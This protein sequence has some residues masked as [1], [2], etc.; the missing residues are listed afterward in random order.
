[1]CHMYG[2]R[3]NKIQDEA[4]QSWQPT[5]DRTEGPLY[6]ALADA[7]EQAI[8]RGELPAGARLPPQRLLAKAL[9]VDLTTITRGY[10]EAQRRGLVSATVG[11]GTFVQAG[12]PDRTA[13]TTQGAQ[14]SAVLDMSM[15]LPPVP[16]APSLRTVLQDGLANLLRHGDMRTLMSYR[17][18]AGTYT[19]RAVAAGWLGPVIG[20]IDPDRVVVAA[21]AQCALTALVTTLTRPG[22][23]VLV[24][25]L[26][27]PGFRAVAAQF[28]VRLV[29]VATDADGPLPAAVERACRG[30]APKAMYL[31]PTIH[32]PSTDTIPPE[33]RDVL[34][35]LA[36]RH[37]MALIE[38]DAYGLFPSVPLTAVT[39]HATGAG[40]YIST[41]AKC[42]APGLR[43]AF[44][45]APGTAEAVRLVS[46]LRATSLSPSPLL[47]NLLTQWLQDGTALALRD[48][49]RSE[50]TERQKLAQAAL[51]TG[52]FASHPEGLHAW[53]TL[54]P[55][56]NR[57]DFCAHV[58]RQGL[59]LVPA[60]AFAIDLPV[61][62]AVRICLGVADR[63]DV[64]DTALRSVA[65]AIQSSPPTPLAE[66]V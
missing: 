12:Q 41:L 20:E 32:N 30:L 9:G 28:G 15:N 50:A 22:D 37:A 10:A 34:A 25:P 2:F 54:P 1:M 62:N 58:R 29:T 16:Q 55:Q 31:V 18:G 11:R 63:R 52:S 65:M 35:A 42:V 26:L 57:L 27:Y 53:L 46:A 44:V 66:V 51:P 36:V 43:L 61:P 17:A 45:V 14:P 6:R 47:T 48:A 13:K 60:D 5:I 8:T 64:L 40:Y 21:G 23:T 7:I 59:A 19:D 38:D 3:H 24:E 39:A 4:M 56:W 49:I 33:R